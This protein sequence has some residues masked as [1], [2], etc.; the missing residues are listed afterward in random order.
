MNDLIA[1]LEK[2]LETKNWYAALMIALTLPDIAGKVDSPN[3]SSSGRYASWF[4]QY[5][6][7]RYVTIIGATLEGYPPMTKQ[8]LNGAD[9]YALRCSFLHEGGSTISHQRAQE[10]LDG[11]V[12][13][14]R[15]EPGESHCNLSKNNKLQLEVA[16]FCTDIVNGVKKWLAAIAN[17][18][19]KQSAMRNFLQISEIQV[20]TSFNI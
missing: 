16:I 11:F 7:D 18:T 15:T 8:F 6:S 12:F 17:D 14:F 4:D 2:S 10:V 9:C 20:L 5:A 3:G 13:G 1:S 19:Q